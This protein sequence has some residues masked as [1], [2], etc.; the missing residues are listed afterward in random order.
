[1]RPPLDQTPSCVEITLFDEALDQAWREAVDA[2]DQHLDAGR[3]GHPAQLGLGIETAPVAFLFG[4]MAGVLGTVVPLSLIGAGP[5]EAA[6]VAAF[7][8]LGVEQQAAVV[9]ALVGYLAKLVTAIEGGV[10][11]IA[12]DARRM[13]AG[14]R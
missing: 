7:V 5:G 13:I 12:G 3:V 11:E 4:S 8:L 14:R 1:M 6:A 10:W 9:I 2:D